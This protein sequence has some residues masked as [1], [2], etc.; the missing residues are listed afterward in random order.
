MGFTRTVD[1]SAL[2][3]WALSEVFLTDARRIGETDYAAAAQLPST[4]A[5]YVERASRLRVP[6]PLLIL[7]CARQAETY[8]GHAFF[9]VPKDS[10]FLLRSWSMSLPGLLTAPVGDR[11]GQLLMHVRTTDRLGVAGDV[12]RLTYRVELRLDGH[13]LGRVVIDVGYV[14]DAVYDVLRAQGRSAPLPPFADIPRTATLLD[15]AQVGRRDPANVV[16]RDVAVGPDGARAVIRVPVENR[17][18]FDH[19]QDHLP[20]MVL[21]EA[22]RQLCLYTSAELFGRSAAH[23]TPVGLDFSFTRYAEL[24]APTTV[25]VLQSEDPGTGVAGTAEE[26]AFHVRFEQGGTVVAAGRMNTA[27]ADARH[28]APR[29][30]EAAR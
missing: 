4:H 3:R 1:R 11:P 27:T 10:K 12:R 22:A 30:P 25:R 28:T 14:P 9:G 26:R 23:T 2:H 7:E 29:T 24:D 19:A 17:S 13:H 21:M 20:G 18:M 15:P 8:G 5:F 6:D 16:L